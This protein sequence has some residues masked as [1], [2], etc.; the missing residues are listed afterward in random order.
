METAFEYGE[1]ELKSLA[2]SAPE[3][4]P[5]FEKYGMIRRSTTADLFTAL[6]QS[7][8][9]QQISTKAQET[10]FNRLIAALG[11]PT[12]KRLLEAPKELLIK[13][14][15]NRRKIDYLHSIATAMENGMTKES[16]QPLSDEEIICRLTQLHGVGV[17]TAEMMLIFCFCRSNVLS[18]GDLGIRT[19][20]ARLHGVETISKNLF[21]SDRARFVPYATVASFYLWESNRTPL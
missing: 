15:V 13:C 8:I 12:P 14:G 1:R 2:Q 11:K 3:L 10:I 9:S 20:L 4:I 16:L 5:L 6:C 19:A 18:Y 7:I 17:W 21:E